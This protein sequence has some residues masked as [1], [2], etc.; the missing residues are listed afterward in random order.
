MAAPA[1][2][3][4]GGPGAAEG[5]QGTAVT[6]GHPRPPLPPWPPAPC[7]VPH[8][9]P[10]LCHQL[11]DGE[12]FPLL[13]SDPLPRWAQRGQRLTRRGVGEGRG[14]G[15]VWGRFDHLPRRHREG[16]ARGP[17]QGLS[18]QLLALGGQEHGL[19]Y[20]RRQGQRGQAGH[21]CRAC[22]GHPR[23]QPQAAHGGRRVHPALGS[24]AT[25]CRAGGT[26]WP[27]PGLKGGC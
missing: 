6:P 20:G 8:A 26:A 1:G 11:G 9:R 15:S 23:F 4:L 3:C 12:A 10:P 16:Q 22:G 27:G 14:V 21:A 13:R 7:P 19:L 5:L 17:A 25:G 2:R 18:G 24:L